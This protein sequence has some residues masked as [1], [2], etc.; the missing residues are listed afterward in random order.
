MANPAVQA[1]Y[2]PAAY[3]LLSLPA[4]ETL[5]VINAIAADHNDGCFNVGREVCG[6]LTGLLRQAS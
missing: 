6:A 4:G 5:S 1:L 3:I 2:R